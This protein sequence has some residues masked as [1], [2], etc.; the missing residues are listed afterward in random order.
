MREMKNSG[1]EWI[2]EIPSDWHTIRFK[3][4][5]NGLNTG[6]AIDKNFWSD[7]I[8]NTTLTISPNITYIPTIP[9]FNIIITLSILCHD[10]TTYRIV[11]KI[12]IIFDMN[13]L[14]L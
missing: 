4:L 7:D 6:E 10:K 3:F 11:V 14:F 9:L 8:N 5:H 1:I 2:G 13:D 12:I